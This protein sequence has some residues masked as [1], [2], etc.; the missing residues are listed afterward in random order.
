MA[1]I[2][3]RAPALDV[4]TACRLSA[5]AAN[6]VKSAA[7]VWDGGL[8]GAWAEAG[9]RSVPALPFSGVRPAAATVVAMR[10]VA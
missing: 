5:Q 8:L 7:F 1:P 6:V 3:A 2:R 9:G 4:A 10:P